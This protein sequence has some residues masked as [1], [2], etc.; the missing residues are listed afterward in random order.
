MS[1]EIKGPNYEIRHK[2]FQGSLPI[3]ITIDEADIYSSK[4][5][6]TYYVMQ[7]RM[8]Y[9]FLM[10]S[11]LAEFYS[12]YL[13]LFNAKNDDFWYSFKGFPLRFDI[14]IGVLYDVLV[15]NNKNSQ[16]GTGEGTKNLPFK[17]T[18]HYTNFP[19][20]ELQKGMTKHIYPQALKESAMMRSGKAS[21]VTDKLDH[22]KSMINAIKDSKYDEFWRYNEDLGAHT[23]DKL[24]FFPVRVLINKIYHPTTQIKD[25]K[26][27]F[28]V[29]QRPVQVNNTDRWIGEYLAKV[30]PK[31]FHIQTEITV[32]QDSS[33]EDNKE[34]GE[35]KVQD[36]PEEVDYIV[37]T[38]KNTAVV[39]N[40]L[41]IDL[42]IS[43]NWLVLNLS[44]M[45]NFLYITVRVN[46]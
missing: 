7:P 8:S 39:I 24:K 13:E 1:E 16:G 34:E 29:I 2:N 6:P 9:L 18:F 46:D 22:I 20:K 3:Q 10:T 12:E 15:E 36:A 42:D 33:D 32:E 11:Q 37:K 30:L 25:E 19:T 31:Y 38:H 40:G 28:I 17:L 44:A 43:L 26:S 27:P 45:D 5:I 35:K 23:L 41:E 21:A 4:D 14:P